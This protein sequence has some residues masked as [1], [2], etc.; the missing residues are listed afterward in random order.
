MTPDVERNE[1][2]DQT[3]L[4]L[5]EKIRQTAHPESIGP[6]PLSLQ[7]C[8]NLEKRSF[9]FYFNRRSGLPI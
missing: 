1:T 3:T 8:L 6:M 4:E 9:F 5:L 2:E 7:V